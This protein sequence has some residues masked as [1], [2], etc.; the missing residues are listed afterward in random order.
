[1][2]IQGFPGII[3]FLHM[4]DLA[5]THCGV[6]LGWCI[7]DDCAIDTYFIVYYLRN[8]DSLWIVS[9]S[10]QAID[11]LCFLPFQVIALIVTT[12]IFSQSSSP[13]VETIFNEIIDS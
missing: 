5:T 6:H 2:Q 13:Y 1:M 11:P 4:D 7:C 9:V 12:Q 3:A 8:G 10:T